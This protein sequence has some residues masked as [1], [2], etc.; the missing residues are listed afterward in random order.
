M[1]DISI[2]KEHHLE[3]LRQPADYR[4]VLSPVRGGQG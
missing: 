3:T 2:Y 1:R 4:P